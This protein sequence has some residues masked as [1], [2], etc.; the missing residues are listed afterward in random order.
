MKDVV[1]TAKLFATGIAYGF[2]VAV[3]V[4]PAAAALGPLFR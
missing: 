4:G 3:A 2:A 1:A